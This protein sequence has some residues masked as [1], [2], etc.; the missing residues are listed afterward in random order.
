MPLKHRLIM[1][2]H[3]VVHTLRTRIWLRCTPSPFFYQLLRTSPNWKQKKRFGVYTR[4][5]SNPKASPTLKIFSEKYMKTNRYHQLI[6]HHLMSDQDVIVRLTSWWHR[7][8]RQLWEDPLMSWWSPILY[9]VFT[10]QCPMY[11]VCYCSYI[12]Q[13]VLL[14]EHC[15]K[16]FIV[17][18]S[19]KDYAWSSWHP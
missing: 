4:K 6:R 12:V 10:V 14:F 13:R 7:N 8:C 1:C 9:T 18:T 5:V 3:N 11:K 19:Y 15:T 16:I 17:S 2:C